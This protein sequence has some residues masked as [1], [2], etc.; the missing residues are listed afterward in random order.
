MYVN[1]SGKLKLQSE[2]IHKINNL[3]I[4]TTYKE[5]FEYTQDIISVKITLC[6]FYETIKFIKSIIDN[7]INYKRGNNTIFIFYKTEHIFTGKITNDNKEI[8]FDHCVESIH[9]TNLIDSFINTFLL[10]FD[11][12]TNKNNNNDKLYI[13]TKICYKYFLNIICNEIK[14]ININDLKIYTLPHSNILKNKILFGSY[15]IFNIKIDEITYY[16]SVNGSTN[17]LIIISY[18]VLNL[19][20]VPVDKYKIE[21]SGIF[22]IFELNEMK[23]NINKQRVTNY[24]KIVSVIMN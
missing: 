8:I 24:N 7:N 5:Y 13:F 19:K 14:S 1:K 17:N 4:L 21:L 16:I 9:N 11:I 10:R 2:N 6:E 15:N 23:Q 12:I 3:P 22:S 20:G 18:G